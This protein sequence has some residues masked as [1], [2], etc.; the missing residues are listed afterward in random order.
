MRTGTQRAA[1]RTTNLLRALSFLTALLL[2]PTALAATLT[3]CPRWPYSYYD[4]ISGSQEDGL[5]HLSGQ[6]YGVQP[7]SYA[8]ATL[9]RNGTAVPP[10]V[11][12][13][14]ILLRGPTSSPSPR[15][16]RSPAARASK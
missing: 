15:T 4:N 16:Q 2:A 7:A 8:Y 14:S 6:N 5:K 10:A 1:R 13:P 3:I 12:P 9:T 11:S